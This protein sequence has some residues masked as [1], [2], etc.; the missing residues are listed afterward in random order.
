MEDGDVLLIHTSKPFRGDYGDGLGGDRFTVNT[1]AAYIQ[2]DIAKTELDKIAVVPNPYVAAASWEAKSLYFTGRGER[3]IEFIHLPR[4]CMIRIYTVRGYLVQTIEHDKD[5]DD[6]SEFWDLRTKD[7]MDVAYGLY[8]YH[9][10]APD[11]GEKI[12]KF[13]IIK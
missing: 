6:G 13:A 2:P 9:I 5:I 3:K 8:I 7:R 12:G 1:K 4:K 10:D 11:I